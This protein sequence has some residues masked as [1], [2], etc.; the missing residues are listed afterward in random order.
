MTLKSTE[1]ILREINVRR[2]VPYG[3]HADYEYKKQ[4][5][6]LDLRQAGTDQVLLSFW[7]E[8]GDLLW[9]KPFPTREEAENAAWQLFSIQP[10]RWLT[11]GKQPS[12]TSL[13]FRK[14]RSDLRRLLPFGFGRDEDAEMS[15]GCLTYAV[16]REPDEAPSGV[17]C[18][19]PDLLALAYVA[20]EA[21]D[22]DRF[23]EGKQRVD[24]LIARYPDCLWGYELYDRYLKW[25][26]DLY[27]PE[28]R[29]DADSF[30]RESIANLEHLLRLNPCDLDGVY[31][32]WPR[33]DGPSLHFLL[34]RHHC[35][36]AWE[37][38]SQQ[39]AQ[40]AL[41]ACRRHLAVWTADDNRHPARE[42]RVM[43][44]EYIETLCASA[45]DAWTKTGGRPPGDAEKMPA[46][47]PKSL[48]YVNIQLRWPWKAGLVPNITYNHVVCEDHARLRLTHAVWEALGYGRSRRGQRLLD[49]LIA[50]YPDCIWGYELRD[51]ALR[52]KS[53]AVLKEK[54]RNFERM[55]AVNPDDDGGGP[56][57]FFEGDIC[58]RDNLKNYACDANWAAPT[59]T[60][61]REMEAICRREIEAERSGFEDATSASDDPLAQQCAAV[62]QAW[63]EAGGAVPSDDDKRA[64][65]DR[66][67][68]ANLL[69]CRVLELLGDGIVV[70][71]AGG[72]TEEI[73]VFFDVEV[74]DFVGLNQYGNCVGK[75]DPQQAMAMLASRAEA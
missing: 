31:F 48:G 13:R 58:I 29:I 7:R 11:D 9:Q 40:V 42:Q 19:D 41:E 50:T 64:V 2:R 5:G 39:T 43:Q 38:A 62:M 52:G 14:M 72:K 3:G 56:E 51:F 53:Y 18:D 33:S 36:T 17:E 4:Q 69:P 46:I 27:E 57:G 26:R 24:E 68:E 70:V 49:T 63:A 66:M 55:L 28:N 60:E 45:V 75:L 34:A 59:E 32:S 54:V 37:A 21:L 35:D 10:S 15:E 12:A 20:M 30:L 65:V 61:A 16:P 25:S 8:S 47:D 23:E 6:T 1:N 74:G 44:A 67:E 22:D 73:D 71:D